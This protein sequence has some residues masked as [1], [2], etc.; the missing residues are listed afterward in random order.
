[1]PDGQGIPFALCK[2]G[3]N[4]TID[5]SSCVDLI[6]LLLLIIKVTHITE[7]VTLPQQTP[8]CHLLKSLYSAL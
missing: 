1:M 2:G 6:K 3:F 4:L 7:R 5:G 8:R